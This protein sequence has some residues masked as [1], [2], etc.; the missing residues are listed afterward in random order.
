[1]EEKWSCFVLFFSA[2]TSTNSEP[3]VHKKIWASLWN[4]CKIHKHDSSPIQQKENG[5]SQLCSGVSHSCRAAVLFIYFL[6]SLAVR[7]ILPHTHSHIY[8]KLE[9]WEV[10]N[11]NVSKEKWATP[12]FQS[13]RGS[14]LPCSPLALTP[15]RSPLRPLP[16]PIPPLN[17]FVSMAIW[18]KGWWWNCKMF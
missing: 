9:L 18:Q 14:L 7:F 11:V 8:L 4:F 5:R 1:M 12:Y 3:K 10:W 2:Q 13:G 15:H 17:H 6:W 16:P